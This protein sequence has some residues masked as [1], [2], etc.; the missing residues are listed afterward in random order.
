M[1]LGGS[2]DRISSGSIAD[3]E[4]PAATLNPLKA[5]CAAQETRAE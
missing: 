3:E 2:S 1:A 5:S 4:G